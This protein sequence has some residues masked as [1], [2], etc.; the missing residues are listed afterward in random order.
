V[1]GSVG[2]NRPESLTEKTLAAGVADLARRDRHLRAVV[3]RFGAPPLWAREP[4][5][6]TLVRIILEQQVSLAAGSAAYARLERVARG[7]TPERIVAVGEG[8]LR[9]A[10]LTR[11]K[12]SYIHGLARAILAGEFDPDALA[13]LDDDAARAELIRLRGIGAWSA[14]IYLLM[15]LGRPDVWPSGDLALVA[16]LREVMRLRAAPSLER[17]RRIA[18]AWRPWRAVAARVLWHHYLSA[19]RPRATAAR[20]SPRRTAARS[21]RPVR[22]DPRSGT[23][24]G[25]LSRASAAAA[26]SRRAARTP[27]GGRRRG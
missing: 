22:K 15:A 20:P 13:A 7:V 5:F 1:H 18:S 10:G 26:S 4:G 25:T 14:D 12:A 19:S 6:E 23:R 11:Q 9:G 16:A 2:A 27:R 21:R 3:A 24:S 17:A 8:T